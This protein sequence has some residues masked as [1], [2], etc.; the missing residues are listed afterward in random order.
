MLDQ[1]QVGTLLLEARRSL[2]PGRRGRY[3]R[4]R[5][6]GRHRASTSCGCRSRLTPSRRSPRFVVG[7]LDVR[8]RAIQIRPAALLCVHAPGQDRCH[9][10]DH[11][12]HSHASLD[13]AHRLT[14]TSA[15]PRATSAGGPRRR[16]PREDRRR[17][18]PAWPVS[19]A[20]SFAV[21]GRSR[22]RR[23]VHERSQD[24]DQR[25][26]NPAC[27][28]RRRPAR[29]GQPVSVHDREQRVD[30][31]RPAGIE[32]ASARSLAIALKQQKLDLHPALVVEPGVLVLEE[33][34]MSCRRGDW[35]APR[36]GHSAQRP[37]APPW[38]MSSVPD[39]QPPW[40]QPAQHLALEA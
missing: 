6:T 24:P 29:I 7:R 17:S 21:V 34:T 16:V 25:Q 3:A 13:H 30:V 28:G 11:Q 5:P 35:P 31:R 18:S 10:R 39:K 1:D 8:A 14:T 26:P 20:A 37:A 4:W 22:G 23:R 12:Q 32:H 36:C 38:T 9:Q 40:S 27:R 19:A 33:G 2:H 15:P